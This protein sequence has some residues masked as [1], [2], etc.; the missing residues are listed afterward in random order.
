MTDPLQWERPTPLPTERCFFL[1]PLA[2]DHLLTGVGSFYG[3]VNHAYVEARPAY[4]PVE[5]VAV[6]DVE[7]VVA[8]ATV[9]RVVIV[10]VVLGPQVVVAVLSV[11]VVCHPVAYLLEDHFVGSGGVAGVARALDHSPD[12][13]GQ[14]RAAANQRHEHHR[15]RHGC[16]HRYLLLGGHLFLLHV[17]CGDGL[18]A[19]C[20]PEHSPVCWGTIACCDESAMNPW[21]I[22]VLGAY[23]P[24]VVEGE[25]DEVELP[26]YGVLRS[27]SNPH[28]RKFD[29]NSLQIHRLWLGCR[30][31]TTK[32]AGLPV[33]YR[34]LMR[35]GGLS[36]NRQG[37]V[38]TCFGKGEL[39]EKVD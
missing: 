20:A 28:P 36:A 29:K 2:N 12:L 31:S 35:K 9:G 24:N 17:G 18:E 30:C 6:V 19:H 10:C 34:P 25:F 38:G 11:D 39:V 23:S 16:Q 26:I 21:S 22:E 8:G 37:I 27:S 7:H 5:G 15:R 3:G 13:L 33:E 14:G 1:H 4:G 32:V